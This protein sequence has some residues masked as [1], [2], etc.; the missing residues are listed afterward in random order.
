M[1]QLFAAEDSDIADAFLFSVF[2]LFVEFGLF[3]VEFGGGA[4]CPDLLEQAEGGA[5][6]G[7]AEI[8]KEQFCPGVYVFG[9]ELQLFHNVVDAV[10]A[11]GD[12]YAGD[13]GDAE[14][15][16]EVVI[17]AAAADAAHADGG[18]FHL[19]DGACVVVQAAGEGEID[20]QGG[21]ER[22]AVSGKGS[23]CGRD[24]IIGGEGRLC[25]GGVIIGCIV[26]QVFQFGDAFQAC[27]VGGEEG[28][29]PG[30]LG[31][32]V[33][34]DVQVLFDGC[35]LDRVEAALGQLFLYL[36]RP[37]LV[38]LV[39]GDGDIRHLFGS[40]AD[41]G[42]GGEDLPVVD[43]DLDGDAQLLE[44]LA[45]DSRQFDLVDEGLA[46]YDVGVAL[47]E[48]AVAA[49]GGTVGAPDGLHLVAFE[50]KGQLSMVHGDKAS[51]RNGEVIAKGSLG[52]VTIIF[53]V[54]DIFE[55][56]TGLFYVLGIAQ[57]VVEDLKDEL[58]TLISIFA[59]EGLQ[60]FQ[61]G[62]FQGLEAVA[63]ENGADGIENIAPFAD[64]GGPEVTGALGQGWF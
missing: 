4:F 22:R 60:L 49:S 52:E 34:G 54:E 53:A 16:G 50:R 2:E 25:V 36:F 6:F 32:V 46:A 30:Q 12:A 8:E 9:K 1:G 13:I 15:A 40:A 44:G 29:Q 57:A 14:E 61:G 45:V 56:F 21:C 47:V 5:G 38:E 41:F 3:V 24:G 26:Q 33:A 39:D 59:H 62:G 37:D 27:L 23:G 58:I 63:L 18:G 20:Y 64:G 17:A 51:E 42:Q 43:P 10:Y 48:F 11:E 19:E 55:G 35:D 7:V 28:F 31:L